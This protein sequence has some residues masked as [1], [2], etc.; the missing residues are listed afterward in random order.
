MA[1]YKHTPGD[2]GRGCS[3]CG[4]WKAWDQY[5]V[6]RN[7]RSGYS[8]DCKECRNAVYQAREHYCVVYAMISGPFVK[9]G[10]STTSEKRT[11]SRYRTGSPTPIE[12]MIWTHCAD[13]DEA[14]GL[15]AELKIILKHRWSHG[16]WYHLY[17][18][19]P[20]TVETFHTK[21]QRRMVKLRKAKPAPE[22][23]VE[24]EPCV[25]SKQAGRQREL[26]ET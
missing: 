21:A 8:A 20:F 2:E 19:H 17:E 3:K 5:V 9:I 6:N 15:E 12:P 7:S 11:L 24:P 18:E 25:H 4:T 13:A 16:E 10:V 14:W 23:V 26:W 1:R 22:P